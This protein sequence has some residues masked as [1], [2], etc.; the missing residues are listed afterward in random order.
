MTASSISTFTLD[1]SDPQW[2]GS[3]LHQTRVNESISFHLDIDENLRTLSRNG[4]S[5][6]L[7]GFLYVP[8]IPDTDSCYNISKPYVF[9]ATHRSDL[10]SFN[11]SL[12]AF[13]PWISSECTHAFL[14]AARTTR[15]GFISAF[16][17]YLPDNGSS[18]PPTANDEVWNLHD[19]GRWKSQN[20]YPVYAIPSDEGE[21]MMSALG[22]YSGN[23]T[24]VPNGHELTEVYDSRDY[25]RLYTQITVG[26]HGLP[27]LWVFLIIILLILLF[28]IALT[29][30][31]LRWIQQRHR[32]D[33]RRRVA[34]GEV[35][36]EALGIK[37]L[38]VPKN[39]LDEMPLYAYVPDKEL[40][41]GESSPPAY[42][43]QTRPASLSAGLG[44]AARTTDDSD[45]IN[46]TLSQPITPIVT[47][48]TAAS[49]TRK[50][51]TQP[52]CPIC[53]DDFQTAPEAGPVFQPSIVRSL[54]CSHIFHPSCIDTFL[55]GTTSLC[56]LCKKSC[57]PRGYIP[58]LSY[59]NA[60]VRRERL[61]RRMRERVVVQDDAHDR[62]EVNYGG[63]RRMASWHRQFGRG[64]GQR[65]YIQRRVVSAPP[66]VEM[67][68]APLPNSGPPTL[69]VPP[70]SHQPN[71]LSPQPHQP[72]SLFRHFQ[73][74]EFHSSRGQDQHEGSPET[75][76]GQHPLSRW[77]K[78]W[79]KI[80]S[81]PTM[82]SRRN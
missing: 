19:G 8:D 76:Q 15:P 34:N 39:I 16:I 43:T 24:S 28:I 66:T 51:F 44:A 41:D 23:M 14:D 33:L 78:V 71:G 20:D 67:I 77:Q 65:R 5:S 40:V 1:F 27:S 4:D 70:H 32:R 64:H 37:R 54:P 31:I 60:M 38:T 13:A 30:L 49:L 50:A 10:P 80:P 79:T 72:I 21:S 6:D 56:P 22:D 69:A 75:E 57:L 58:K 73:P 2:T 82:R 29:S 47:P 35:D 12:I 74:H 55:L 36:L 59:S 11:H 25:V 62:D 17:T 45:T 53:L 26:K 61:V 46:T 81:L 9:N 42:P 7:A 63:M 18:Q 68:P 48:T 52:T 3:F